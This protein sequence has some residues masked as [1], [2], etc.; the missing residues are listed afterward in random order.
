MVEKLG[1][2]IEK[3]K[4]LLVSDIIMKLDQPPMTELD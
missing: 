1:N 3:I 4:G 2:S